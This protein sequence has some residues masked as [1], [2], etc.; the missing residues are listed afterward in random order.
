[1]APQYARDQPQGFKNRVE[2]IAIVGA[3]GRVGEFIAKYLLQTGK[4][5]VT[6]LTRADSTNKLPSG[7]HVAKVNYDDPSTLVSALKGQDALIIT[8]AVMAPPG[9]QD[10]LIEAAAE[11][12]VPWVIP[13]DWGLDG[14]N[15]SLGDDTKLGPGRAAARQLIEKLGKSSWISSV[16]GFWYEFS[17]AGSELRYG[18]DFPSKTVTFFDDGNTKINTST[19]EQCGRAVA[20]LFSLKVLPEDAG[21]EGPTVSQFGNNYLFTS[22]FLV[23]QRDML[24]SV[25]RVTGESETDWTI[26]HEDAKER[27]HDGVAQLQSGNMGGFVKLLY[28]RVFYPDGS[29]NFEASKGLHN[30]LLGL[31]KE[32]LDEATKAAIDM[33]LNGD[34]R[35]M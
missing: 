14:D 17:L 18:F 26:K 23:S 27:Y 7:V 19:W 2:N 35:I 30:E 5:T 6:A 15:K 4:H 22:S 28:T 1:M 29:G 24:D 32:D 8:M 20:S 16:C 9:S 25:L 11:A 13:N 12:G 3:G 10:K 33:A 31:P 34:S 21:D